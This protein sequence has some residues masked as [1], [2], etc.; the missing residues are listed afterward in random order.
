MFARA[1]SPVEAGIA[2]RDHSENKESNMNRR[3]TRRGSSHGRLIV[4]FIAAMC[5]A[6]GTVQAMPLRTVALTGQQAPGAENGVTFQSFQ[7]PAVDNNGRT[8]FTAEVTG[9]NTG[10]WSEG[11]GALSKIMRIGDGAPGTPPQ[12]TFG[13]LDTRFAYSP[14]GKV[15]FEGFL[16]GPG[17][18]VGVNDTGVWSD[19]TGAL[20]LV[21]L[22]GEQ[23]AGLDAGVKY[24]GFSSP[25]M[26][27]QNV[28]G[29][30]GQFTP[31]N[32]G[33]WQGDAN[34]LTAVALTGWVPPDTPNGTRYAGVVSPVINSAANMAW[35]GSLTGPNIFPSND[36]GLWT[37]IGGNQKVFQ[38]GEPAPGTPTG[39]EEF[40]NF[41]APTIN[42][43][44]KVAVRAGLSG[45][46]TVPGVNDQGIWT[47][48]PNN[49]GLL[50][51]AGA[52]ATGAEGQ[53]QTTPKFKTFGN[54]VLG[55]TN[56]CAFLATLTGDGITVGENDTGVWRTVNAALEFVI[57]RGDQDGASGGVTFNQLFAPETNRLNQV[58][59]FAIVK[60]SPDG[61]PLASI[62]TTLS[63][64]TLRLVAISGETLE[65][66]QGDVRTIQGVDLLQGSGG[67]DGRSTSLGPN[68][69]V[70]F[71]AF[72]TDGS[73]GVFV[74]TVPEPAGLTLIALG[75]MAA[76][77]V[78][79]LRRRVRPGSGSAIKS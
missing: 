10:I 26:N 12:S 32:F 59:F 20:S 27:S 4:P 34:G 7:A 57:Q 44:G 23:A 19:G 62:W 37:T 15:G 5:G 49:M 39:F 31:N 14:S 60:R 18:N 3:C 73:Q 77:G 33:I 24:T 71:M 75:A 17:I 36:K 58:A 64:G 28:L 52:D 6:G 69:E 74:R 41:A 51:R 72:F 54:P 70:A 45:G 76:T 56:E 61:L 8:A 43:A 47:G 25:V 29:L 13:G 22:R 1:V 65:V 78:R 50:V 11:S 79:R 55:G 48:D 66:A 67:E 2:Q 63:D 21:A 38:A 16:T 53:P 9:R 42:N 40:T 35:F 68:G 30:S 46:D